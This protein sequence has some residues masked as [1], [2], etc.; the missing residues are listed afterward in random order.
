[1]KILVTG[2]SGLVGK[3]VVDELLQH[4]HTVG[5][6]DLKPPNQ[7]VKHHRVDVLNLDDVVTSVKGY[8]A[9][10]HMAGIPHPLNDPAEK[11]FSVN[12]NGT[13]NVLEAAA[14]NKV[15]KVVFTS[16]ESTLGFAFMTNRMAPEYVPIDELHPLRPQDPYGLSKVIGEQ[17]CRTY[18][19]LYRIRTVCLREPWIW[20]P[21]GSEREKYKQLVT[22]HNKW[23]KNLWSFVHVYDVAQA[24]RLAV[25]N[26]LSSLHEVFF[27]TA[28]QN[29]TG[30]DSRDLLETHFPEVKNFARDFTGPAS[31]LSYRKAKE[32]L[33]YEPRHSVRDILF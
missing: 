28:Q 19:A 23:Y 21:E 6:L 17:I 33:G 9:V 5:V 24:H 7:K 12:V 8:D 4:K 16:S 25:E 18:S 11:I 10:V 30:I 1:M 3:Y 15:K 2:G 14:R 27:I 26:D 13:F 31:I 20:V 32:L 29:W 22:E